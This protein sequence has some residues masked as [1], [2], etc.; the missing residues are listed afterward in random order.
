V[1]SADLFGKVEV[2][3]VAKA[4]RDFTQVEDVKPGEAAFVV[5][6]ALA[7]A[8]NHASVTSML[9][10]CQVFVLQGKEIQK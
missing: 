3:A 4:V 5:H 6:L 7:T 8:A 10:S 1:A 9:E 2:E